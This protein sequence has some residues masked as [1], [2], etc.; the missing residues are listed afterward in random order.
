M[1]CS[2]RQMY[3]LSLLCLWKIVDTVIPRAAKRSKHD[4]LGQYGQVNKSTTSLE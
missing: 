4:Y 1:M 3:M 2:R